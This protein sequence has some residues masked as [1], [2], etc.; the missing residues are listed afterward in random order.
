MIL[1]SRN[2]HGMDELHALDDLTVDQLLDGRYEGDAPELAALRQLVEQVRS[3]A[4]QPAPRPSPAL[5]QILSGSAPLSGDVLHR[6]RTISGPGRHRPRLTG[7]PT[8]AAAVSAALLAMII[9]AGSARLLPGPTQDLV[10][11]IVRAVTPFH[12]P[13]QPEPDAV[14]SRAQGR[15]THPPSEDPAGARAASPP[16]MAESGTNG[17]RRTGG[18][19]SAG[20]PPPGGR[21]PAPATSTTVTRGPAPAVRGTAPPTVPPTDGRARGGVTGPAPPAPPPPAPKPGGLSADLGGGQSAGGPVGHGSATLDTNPGKNELCLT[22]TLS[23]TAPVTS[24][25]LHAGSVGVNGPVVATFTAPLTAGTSRMCVTVTD[26]LMKEIRRAPGNY[27][28]DV[29]TSDL[30]NGTLRGQ[31]TK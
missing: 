19:R 12:F 8:V 9:V 7:V 20:H 29:H 26:Q 17:D 4:G 21:T 16:S 13:Q 1:W 18:D 24:V 3:L 27:Y 2:G 11:R 28:V 6:P 5:A 22:L 30:L 23:G 10:A 25:H 14:L 15:G 31:L